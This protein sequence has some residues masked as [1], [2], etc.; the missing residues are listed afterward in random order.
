[1]GEVV[2]C[3]SIEDTVEDDEEEEEGDW[4][5]S[6]VIAVGVSSSS[7]SLISSR[8]IGS[9]V[10]WVGGGIEM[11]KGGSCGCCWIGG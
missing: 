6:V 7:I 11:D 5:S 9:F 2:F 1:M 3:S 8:N 4:A 10:C